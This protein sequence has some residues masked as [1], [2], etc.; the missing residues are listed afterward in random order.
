MKCFTCNKKATENHHIIP[1]SLGGKK[2]IPLC[3]SCHGLLHGM[4]T[5]RRD[6]HSYLTK[7]GL[8]R[9]KDIGVKLGNPKN[10]TSEGRKKG[11]KANSI[12]A[13]ARNKLLI[14]VIKKLDYNLSLREICKFLNDN[15]Y[16]TSRGCKFK[17]TT[18]K[19]LKDMINPPF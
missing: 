9:A 19:R 14:D 18:V 16:K 6:N 5:T 1:K 15:G 8:Q 11:R 10:F 3:G 12:K 4:K 13:A 2:T 17:P 7:L